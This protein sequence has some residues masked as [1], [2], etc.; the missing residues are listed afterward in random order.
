VLKQQYINALKNGET[1]YVGA[2]D[3]IALTKEVEDGETS[4]ED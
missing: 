4:T 3:S 2:D 1:V